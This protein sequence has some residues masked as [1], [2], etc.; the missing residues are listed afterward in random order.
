MAKEEFNG[1]V[2]DGRINEKSYKADFIK[3]LADLH[4]EN[5]PFHCQKLKVLPEA[6]KLIHTYAKPTVFE[7]GALICFENVRYDLS[8]RCQ[9]NSPLRINDAGNLIFKC[10]SYGSVIFEVKL[11]SE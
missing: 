6:V 11:I 9:V 1:R 2:F 3:Y 5:L 7:K 10:L 4:N 8:D